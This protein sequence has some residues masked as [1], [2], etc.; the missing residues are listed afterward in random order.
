MK[1]IIA[2]VLGNYLAT[3]VSL[4]FYDFLFI[5]N[6]VDT[7]YAFFDVLWLYFIFA[8]PV[9]ALIFLL[10][11]WIVVWDKT[12]NIYLLGLLSFFH[13]SLVLLPVLENIILLGFTGLFIWS[14]LFG[15]LI[16]VI[17][18]KFKKNVHDF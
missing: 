1:K 3:F 10:I 6:S 13:Q 4:F 15:I 2:I 11:F 8:S 16:S 18:R 9:S 12:E 14:I 5:Q 17:F 7:H